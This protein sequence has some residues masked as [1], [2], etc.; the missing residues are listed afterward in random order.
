MKSSAGFDKCRVDLG[1]IRGDIALFCGLDG[2]VLVRLGDRTLVGLFLLR[3]E[4][5][6]EDRTA[7]PR[8]ASKAIED[9]FLLTSATERTWS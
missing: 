8:V 7:P 4:S 1:I 9:V 5:V 2:I 3:P 6:S